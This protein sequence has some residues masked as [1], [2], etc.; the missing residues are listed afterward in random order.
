MAEDYG[1]TQLTYN[2]YLK[3][4]EL[5]KQQRCLSDPPSHDE[6][7][8]IIV[9]QAYELW[10]K[11]MLFEI[12][13]IKEAMNRSD[14]RTATWLFRRVNAI[15]RLLI[16]QIHILESMSPLDFLEFRG[17]LNPASGFQS[18][19]FR[20]LEFVSNLKDA[21][22]MTHLKSDPESL[23]KLQKRFDEPTLWDAFLELL[24]KNGF[25]I[26]ADRNSVELAKE[27]SRLH[28]ESQKYYELFLLAEE[29]MAFDEHIGLWRHHHVRMVERMIGNKMGTGGSQGV[30]YLTSTLTKKC[31]PELWDART[32]LE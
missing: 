13:S 27:L 31:F 21:N 19:Q 6:L 1:K 2:E 9:H 29:M 32:Y 4:P 11:L 30:K 12:D 10:F 17:K 24:Q 5:L 16:D 20:E 25:Q 23:A 7:Q 18:V 26:P 15:A 14:V 8:F 22:I 3:V 28:K